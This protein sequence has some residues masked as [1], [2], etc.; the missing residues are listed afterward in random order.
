MPLPRMSPRGRPRNF[1]VDEALGNALC[2]F[3]ENGYE[4]TSLAD[5]TKAMGIN[6]P[7]LYATFGNKEQLFRKALDRYINE[8][9]ECF[10]ALLN[11]DDARK[12]LELV[13]RNAADIQTA[14]NHPRGCLLVQGAMSC[15]EQAQPIKE[16]LTK[17]RGEAEK[18]LRLRFKR[19]Q[20]EGE[21]AANADPVGLARFYAA[22]M[23]GMSVQAASGANRKALQSIITHAML[24]WPEA[25]A[26]K[27]KTTKAK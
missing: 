2:V 21:I 8:G 6:R 26:A 9:S 24:A 22:V 17:R 14:G 10:R 25:A 7:S 15:G 19:A 13:L 18:W 1:D 23:Q 12:S 27:R 16:E 20:E 4:G 3:W 5:L 11:G